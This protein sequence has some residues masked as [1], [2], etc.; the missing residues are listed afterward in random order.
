MKDSTS[1]LHRLLSRQLRRCFGRAEGFGPRMRRFLGLVDQAYRDMERDRGLLERSI[2]LTS[3]ELQE[4]YEAAQAEIERRR[5]VEAALE[6]ARCEAER[7]SR[8][9]SVFLASM[10]HEI[11]TPL[12]AILATLEVLADTERD[13]Q[14]LRLVEDAR[15]A[16][17]VLLGLLNGVLDLAR[18]ES[19]RM[20]L[21]R[22]PFSLRDCLRAVAG[23][24][25][26]TAFA[27]GVE[28]VIDLDPRVADQ[29]LGDRLRL[30]QVLMNLAGNAVKFTERGAVRLRVDEAREGR[31]RIAV[32]DSGRGI[33]ADR[34][35]R[36]FEAFGQADRADQ[37]RH[38]G[39]GLGLTLASHFVRLMGGRIHVES[40]L[41]KGSS[42]SFE[43]DLPPQGAPVPPRR[44]ELAGIRVSVDVSHP[45]LAAALKRSLDALGAAVGEG[46]VLL[47]DHWAKGSAPPGRPVLLLWDR[48]PPEVTRGSRIAS[49]RKPVLDSDLVDSL[50][51]LLAG[52]PGHP[53]RREDVAEGP[54]FPGAALVVDDVELNRRLLG[55]VLRRAGGEVVEA[56]SGGQAIELYR[57][58][59]FDVVLLDVELGDIDG[60]E[61]ARRLRRIDEE[62]GTRGFLVAVTARAFAEDRERCLEAGMDAF[63]PK[64]F[65][66]AE[67]LAL[68]ERVVRP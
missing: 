12:H 46:D 49:V 39:T 56:S 43:A 45:W 36:I 26:P 65:E 55:M 16:G 60:L 57:S 2:E 28:F 54:G 18:I 22:E 66:K 1:A 19:G 59:P 41:G 5:R 53:E 14:R 15:S 4:R 29:R 42:F 35:E 31:L 27:K 23:T 33:P 6:E 38:G 13:P 61:T 67:L 34:L 62:R 3:R 47:T 21:V 17:S 58:R 68:L 37:H 32:E 11:R 7:A 64:P 44:A 9:K 10:S 25:A 30:E 51:S 52:S 8:A 50:R 20:E 63:L 24:A 48:D 40:E